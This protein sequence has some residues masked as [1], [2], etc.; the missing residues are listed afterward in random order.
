MD[1]PK[2]LVSVRSV[3]EAWAALRGGADWIDLKEPDQGPLGAVAAA[4]GRDVVQQVAGRVPISAAAGELIDWSNGL[5]REL[6]S[7][8]GIALM[9]LGLSTCR[10]TDWRSRWRAAQ[11]EISAADVQLVAVIYADHQR[12][13]APLPDEIAEFAVETDCSWVLVDTFDKAGG[14]VGDHLSPT[15]LQAL[16]QSVQDGGRRTV[17]AGSLTGETIAALPMDLID[18]VAVRTAACE[19]GRGGAV[20]EK[21]VAELQALLAI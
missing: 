9:K 7:A 18:M 10:G 21:R 20:C 2:L 8:P 15:K 4:V 19:G 1:A 6:L 13:D 3:D 17:V 16:L 14:A 11:R 12:A 5:S